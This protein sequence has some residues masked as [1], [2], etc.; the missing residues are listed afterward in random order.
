M[1]YNFKV[2]TI[3]TILSFF[4]RCAEHQARRPVTQQSGSFMKE[5]I[6]RNKKLNNSEEFVLDSVMKSKPQNI[7]I[8]SQKGYWYCYEK[9]SNT[10]D[11]IRPKRGDVVNFDYSINDTK[12]NIIYSEVELKTQN[13]IVD[14]ENIMMGLRSGIKLMKKN[15]SVTFLFPSNIAFGY[16][17][18]KDKI[19]AN[20]PLI[21]TVTVNDIKSEKSIKPKI[22]IKPAVKSASETTVWENKEDPE[23]QLKPE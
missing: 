2:I 9:K 16:F 22:S 1:K 3:F 12:G 19:G 7:Y 11:T 14:K 6:E 8:N 20:T 10:V 21:C 18:D 5:S 17:G 13:Y 4:V 15:E 23:Q